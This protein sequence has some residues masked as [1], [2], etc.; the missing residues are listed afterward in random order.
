M[1]EDNS[2]ID[3]TGGWSLDGLSRDSV[4]CIDELLSMIRILSG[5]DMAVMLAAADRA[6]GL[7]AWEDWTAER[8]ADELR[9]WS[10]TDERVESVRKSAVREWLRGQLAGE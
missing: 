10:F 9:A 6:A 7:N 4:E 3:D 2:R 5:D 1:T 8:L